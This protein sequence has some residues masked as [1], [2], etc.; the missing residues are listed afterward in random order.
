MPT[1]IATAIG[2]AIAF[3]LN[4]ILFFLLG[5]VYGNTRGVPLAPP[6]EVAEV[7]T[8]SPA[9][10]PTEPPTAA[11]SPTALPTSTIEPTV[12][13]P[14][15][16]AAPTDTPTALP[17]PTIT[18]TPFIP[19]AKALEVIAYINQWRIQNGLWP[20]KPNPILTQMANDQAAYWM[21]NG[22]RGDPHLDAEGRDPEAR[23]A[24]VYGWPTYGE[25]ALERVAVG[26]NARVDSSPIN[27]VNWWAGSSTHRRTMGNLTYREIGVAAI[28][29]TGGGYVY[30]AV[31]GSRPDVFP[32]LVNEAEG[33]I[34]LTDECYEWAAGGDEWIADVTRFQFVAS[35]DAQPDEAAWQLW[36]ETAS[37]PQT[38]APWFLALT[39]GQRVVVVTVDPAVD[40]AWLPGNLP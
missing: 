11:A 38:P 9:A 14:T 40:V 6:T 28:V 34:Y 10:T 3:I 17:T 32:A 2:L 37:L 22:F 7:T 24:L 35:P 39:D 13:P 4:S 19:D 18:P 20:L 15:P 23:A 29:S 27:A 26:E 8:A 33:V 30:M 31:F 21:G 1:R 36:A 12:A 5:T 25:P 16:T